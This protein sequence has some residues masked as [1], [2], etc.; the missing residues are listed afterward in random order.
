MGQCHGGALVG[1]LQQAGAV[2]QA[3]DRVQH[4]GGGRPPT[5]A[6]GHRESKRQFSTD[7]AQA[8]SPV[9]R[10]RRKPCPTRPVLLHGA[11]GGPPSLTFHIKTPQPVRFRF[12]PAAAA[13]CSW[14]LAFLSCSAASLLAAWAGLRGCSHPQSSRSI[15]KSVSTYGL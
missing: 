4:L 5:H 8:A 3:E 7:A 13:S 14:A 10:R 11:A 12:F 6:D 15:S 2:V 9:T 1:G